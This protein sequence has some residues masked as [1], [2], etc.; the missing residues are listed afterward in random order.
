MLP[1]YENA[2]MSMHSSGASKASVRL[3]AH[4]GLENGLYDRRCLLRY[5]SIVAYQCA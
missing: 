3:R 1:A 5:L 2:H 4:L